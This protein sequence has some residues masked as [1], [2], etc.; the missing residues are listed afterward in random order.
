MKLKLEKL[1]Y[2]KIGEI[3]TS[4]LSQYHPDFSLPIPIEEI[5]E[6]QIDLEIIPIK[7]LRTLSDVDGSLDSS[8]SKIF[9]D[10]DLYLNQENR[11]RFTIAHEI[12]HLVLHKDLFKN[13]NIQ[14]PKDIYELSNNICEEDYGWLEYQAY[15]FAGHVLVPQRLLFLEVKKRLGDIPKKKFIPEMIFPI[16]QELL[17]VFNVS[18]EVLSRRLQKENIISADGV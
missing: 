8:L 13:L 15:T 2:I 16:S 10:M 14:K 18:G 3:A 5:A 4:F 9:I 6:Q 12:G 11:T 17:D 7:N 1:S